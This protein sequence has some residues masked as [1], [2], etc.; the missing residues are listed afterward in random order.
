MGLQETKKKAKY[1]NLKQS[2]VVHFTVTCT[3]RLITPKNCTQN[4][5]SVGQSKD[6]CLNVIT[7]GNLPFLSER[8]LSHLKNSNLL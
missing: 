1:I 6:K 4:G 2:T 7:T 8:S 5:R 3:S